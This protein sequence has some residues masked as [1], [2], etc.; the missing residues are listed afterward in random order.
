[1]KQ[2]ARARQTTFDHFHAGL[3]RVHGELRQQASAILAA[4]AGDGRVPTSAGQLIAGF[5]EN[6]EN[7]HRSEDVFFFPAFRAAGRLRSTDI[8]FLDARDDEHA[9]LVRL[10]GELRPLAVRVHHRSLLQATWRGSIQR[11]VTELTDIANPHFAAEESVLTPDH[12]TE[13][14]SARDLGEV[15]RDMGMNWNRR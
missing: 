5:C 9:A 3:L 10:V 4:A 2:P 12:V 1:M 15:Y 6:L 7:H 14:I 8:A 11:L 13:M